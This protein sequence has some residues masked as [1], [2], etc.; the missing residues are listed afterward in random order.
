MRLIAKRDRT[1]AELIDKLNRKGFSEREIDETVFY[2]KQK[3]FLDD[4]KFIEKAEKIAQD[5]FLGNMGIKNYLAKKGIDKE[6]LEN[7]P[8][9]DEFLIAQRLIQR[10]LHLI[11]ND[12]T[13]K[14]KL[15][16]TG[17]L[18]RRGF[19]WDTVN[20]CLKEVLK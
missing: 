10:K 16:I 8:E 20:K 4:T 17:F 19:S 12:S 2:L 3:G 9:I 1:E 15:K 18:L 7:V 13:D 6:L 5:R 11:K 14:K